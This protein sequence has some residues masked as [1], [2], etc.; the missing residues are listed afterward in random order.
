MTENQESIEDIRAKYGEPDV[1]GNYENKWAKKTQWFYYQEDGSVRY[2]FFV[3]GKA[4][5]DMVIT[6]EKMMQV[7]YEDN[8]L[9]E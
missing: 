7:L 5:W 8:S 1:I 6:E 3:A 9:K 2:C 4:L